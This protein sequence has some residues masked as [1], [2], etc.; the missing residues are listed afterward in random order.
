MFLSKQLILSVERTRMHQ[1][2]SELQNFKTFLTR[3]SYIESELCYVTA[4]VFS[5][6]AI[7]PWK[8]VTGL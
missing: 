2:F 3:D 6:K 5:L 4:F 8:E 1:D 7:L